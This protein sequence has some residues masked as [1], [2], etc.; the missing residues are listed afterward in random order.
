MPQPIMPDLVRRLKSVADPSLSP[1]GSRLAYTLSRIDGDEWKAQSRIVILDLTTEQASELTDGDHDTAPRFSPDGQTIAFLRAE[2]EHPK[3][4][5][6]I[7]GAGGPARRVSHGPGAVLDF[8]WSP[9]SQQLVYSA[10]VNPDAPAEGADNDDLPRT[11][12]VRRIK[13]RFD[14]LGWRGD[15][16]FHLFVADVSADSTR[17]LTDGDWDDLSP[18]WSPDGD[19]IAFISGRRDDRDS[20]AQ[21][22]AYVVPASGGEPSLWSP[23]LASVAGVIWS[24]DN[25]KLL[26][27]GSETPGLSVIWQGWLYILEP[28][29][30]ARRITDDSFRPFLGFPTTGRSPEIRWTPE[31]VIL[32]LGERRGESF[33]YQV[34]IK[35][36][37]SS[38]L[39]GGSRLSTDLSLDANATKAVLLSSS[40]QSPGDLHYVDLTS[41]TTRQL[42]HYNHD[43]LAQHPPARMEKFS[44]TRDQWSIE[45]RLYFPSNFD[46]S[47]SYPLVLDVHGGPNGAYYDSFVAWQQILAT[48]GYLVLAVNPRGSS[49]YGDDFM[50]AVVGD[51]GGE[52]YLDLMAAVDQ[53]A[54][55]SYIDQSRLGIHGYSYGGYMSSWTV[56]HTDRFKAAVIGAPCTNLLSM[57][58]SSDIGIS[59]GEM[60]WDVSVIESG[61]AGY[62]QMAHRL[63][64]KSP[65]SYAANVATPVLLLHG[66]ADARCPISQSEEYFTMLKRLGKEVEMVRFPD[67]SHLFLRT[68]HPKMREEYLARTLE[69]FNR[70]LG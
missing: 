52:D 1:D 67:C 37:E 60:Q 2:D 62:A 10:D 36:Q 29:Q 20:T 21:N 30:D 64:K 28:G 32:L 13:Y 57:Y 45:C 16:H 61:S 46:P 3:Q 50:M 22:E 35:N 33:L 43:Y 53:V 58:G 14:T 69:W 5:W 63:L 34:S 68:G 66:E 38:Q 70:H 65:I 8:A 56:G 40:T 31:G 7:N 11:R 12:E 18:T 51:W 19:N 47:R 54:A 26:V 42:T 44:I 49:T 23:G 39:L 25:L 24:P 15:S 41:G 59:F 48:N 27:V 17:Q 6:V 9:D 4:V 55:R